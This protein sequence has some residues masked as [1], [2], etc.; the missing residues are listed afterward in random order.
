MKKLSA[1]ILLLA[2]LPV[3]A[4]GRIPI[5][6]DQILHKALKALGGKEEIEKVQ[7]RVVS[8]HVKVNGIA[9]TYQLWAKTPNKLKMRLDIGIN[10]QE[11]AFDGEKGWQK[12]TNIQELT[13]PDLERLKRNAV[14]NPLLHHLK[15]ATPMKLR[16]KKCF[17]GTKPTSWNLRLQTVRPK[18]STLTPRRF[19]L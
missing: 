7:T 11:R 4:Q 13:G 17:R 16:D 10:L 14:F 19:F 18:S 3:W 8:A 9:G 12:Q 6:A 15:D 1:L 5:P 2:F